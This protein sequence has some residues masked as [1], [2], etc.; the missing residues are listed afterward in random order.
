MRLCGLYLST[1][2]EKLFSQ[3]LKQDNLLIYLKPIIISLLHVNSDN[4][5]FLWKIIISFETKTISDE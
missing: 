1:L 4:I 3:K 2:T 5:Y